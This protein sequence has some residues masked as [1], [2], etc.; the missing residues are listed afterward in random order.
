MTRECITNV[1]I[2][3]IDALKIKMDINNSTSTWEILKKIGYREAFLE[4]VERRLISGTLKSTILAMD[5]GSNSVA[6]QFSGTQE[7]DP[8]VKLLL[9][10]CNN[11]K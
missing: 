7:A 5:Y 8:F 6:M 2:T 11:L 1:E 10:N 3:G 9:T 4:D